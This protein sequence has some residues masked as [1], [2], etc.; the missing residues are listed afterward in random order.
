MRLTPK[1]EKLVKVMA[2]GKAIS[3][4]KAKED[5]DICETILLMRE[6][7]EK[8]LR[9]RISALAPKEKPLEPVISRQEEIENA[10]K[11]S[12]REYEKYHNNLMKEIE[13]RMPKE[14]KGGRDKYN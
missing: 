6:N 5:K 7:K 13:D 14:K 4:E 3:F 8:D 9:D 1:E 12:A 11:K 10:R 2:I